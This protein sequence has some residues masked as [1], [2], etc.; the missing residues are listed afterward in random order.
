LLLSAAATIILGLQDLNFWSSVGFSLTA[1]VT[2]ASAI[3]P[4]FAWRFRWVLMEE[5]QYEFL[6][7]ADDIKYHLGCHP[8]GSLTR[9]TVDDLYDRYQVAWEKLSR[10]WLDH[11]RLAGAGS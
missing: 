10:Q 7:I 5:A 11:R 2:L 8:A 4:F 9:E 6:R 3:E 1:L